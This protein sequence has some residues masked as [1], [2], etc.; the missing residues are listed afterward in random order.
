MVKQEPSIAQPQQ[1]VYSNIITAL[2]EATPNVGVYNSLPTPDS[3]PADS[4]HAQPSSGSP[5]NDN[6]YYSG[7]SPPIAIPVSGGSGQATLTN[8]D[9]YERFPYSRGHVHVVAPSHG[10]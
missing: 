8:L 9:S 6:G 7:P 5:G 4:S 1:P 3:S 10:E 2:S